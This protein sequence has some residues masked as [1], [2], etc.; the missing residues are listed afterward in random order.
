MNIVRFAACAATVS[1][2]L[3]PVAARAAIPASS[4]WPT[5]AA[6]ASSLLAFDT[7]LMVGA[8]RCRPYDRSVAVHYD[9]L[10]GG[11]TA[12]V[13]EWADDVRGHFIS[14]RG[15]AAGEAAF[16]EYRTAIGNVQSAAPVDARS[17]AVLAAYARVAAS[18]DNAALLA[19]A[20]AVDPLPP[21]RCAAADA[22]PGVVRS[23][24]SVPDEGAAGDG[25]D[26][27]PAVPAAVVPAVVP[28]VADAA[29]TAPAPPPRAAAALADAARALAAAAAALDEERAPAV[30]Q[31]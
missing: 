29:A 27:G 4:C 14:D 9:R 21:R 10:A 12:A 23:F 19:L 26:A 24:A 8:L 17:C 20:E 11:R 13:A 3:S 18:A 7:M 2:V 1:L 31:R 6:T 28:T 30:P 25:S 16:E 15:A 22:A 5:E